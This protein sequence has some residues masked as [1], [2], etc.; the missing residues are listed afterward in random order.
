MAVLER[1]LN[2][3]LARY[4]TAS[5]LELPLRFLLFNKKRD[6]ASLGFPPP[7]LRH[8]RSVRRG[9]A[10]LMEGAATRAATAER[11]VPTHPPPELRSVLLLSGVVVGVCVGGWCTGARD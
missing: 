5:K 9:S 7:Y 10:G 3:L 1:R 6:T 2:T 11:E 8:C 4:G